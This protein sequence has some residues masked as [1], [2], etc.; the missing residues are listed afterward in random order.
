MDNSQNLNQ[1][2]NFQVTKKI[3]FCYGHR[4]IN[5]EGKCKYLHG[6]NGIIEIDI[7]SSKLNKDSMVIDFNDIAQI[8]KS[9]IN[10]NIDH[11]MILSKN[12]G[13]ISTFKQNGEPMYIMDGN[14][15]AE[16][17]AKHIFHSLYSLGL[18]I[19]ELRLWETPNSRASY[20]KR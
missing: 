13:I 16:N 3:E 17:I 4:L 19:I 10:D 9:W 12:D 1:I 18:N 7:D 11:K 6:H 15:T 20:R 14:P 8:A 5:Y 2:E